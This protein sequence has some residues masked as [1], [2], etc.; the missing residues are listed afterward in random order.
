MTFTLSVSGVDH[1]PE[2]ISYLYSYIGMLR[3]YGENLPEWIYLE[4][5]SMHD[6]AYKYTDEP[7]PEDL[8]ESLAED[9]A[10][11]FNLPPQH[12]L[13][14]SSLLFEY[15]PKEI[16]GLLEYFTP[17]N[18]RIDFMSTTFGRPLDFESLPETTERKDVL[19]PSVKF[20]KKE[21]GPPHI[22]PWFHTY[23][24]VQD[25]SPTFLQEWSDRSRPQMPPKELLLSL[26]PQNPFVPTTFDLKPL[27]PDDCHHALLNC[28]LKL[29]ITVG[30]KK[31]CIFHHPSN[32]FSMWFYITLTV[33][34]ISAMVPWHSY[35]I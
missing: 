19:E 30:K 25:V 15:D 13:D 32:A 28:S 4:L 8:V 6:L 34:S 24:W 33:F 14:G 5:R 1:W 12:I 3:H 20:D 29:C 17:H 10:P 16:Q 2:V 18:S 35:Q 11:F 21:A 7:S 31:V 23:Y 26:P 27:P 9:M 22:D